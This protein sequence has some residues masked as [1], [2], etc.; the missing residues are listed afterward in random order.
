MLVSWH[1]REF[2]IRVPEFRVLQSEILVRSNP[3]SV[4]NRAVNIKNT[5]HF[6][7]NL[8]GLIQNTKPRVC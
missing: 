6:P 5:R 8:F 1:R 3:F 7:A 4:L 2:D